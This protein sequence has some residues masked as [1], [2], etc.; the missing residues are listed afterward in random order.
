MH[1]KL[2]NFLVLFSRLQRETNNSPANL[3]WLPT[4]KSD[5][6][7]L[8][9]DLDSCYKEI[10]SFLSTKKTK[11]TIAPNRFSVK[12]DEFVEN[13]AARVSEAAAPEEA[14]RL[15]EFQTLLEEQAIKLGITLEELCAGVS[16]GLEEER[17]TWGSF[18]PLIDDA[19][20]IM[21]DIPGW[22]EHFVI[23]D[24]YMDIFDDKMIGAWNFFKDTIG[25]DY[26]AIYARWR[27]APE[28]FI[29][30]QALNRDITPIVDLY[31]EAVRTYIFGLTVSS[32]A[33]CRAVLEH[34]LKKHYRIKGEDLERIIFLAEKRHNH[35][36]GLNLKAKKNDA[37]AVLHR[38]EE[39]AKN[40]DKAALDFLIALRHVVT[41]IPS[42]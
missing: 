30:L 5:L 22:I 41:H 40:L 33:M 9:Y 38:Y 37:N 21:S 16:E 7:S 13:W 1:T 35:L 20:A 4:E 26:S 19:A 23:N 17:T 27:N 32:V 15:I 36:K 8:C 39:R 25:I 42:P 34:V 10:L 18:D 2:Q 14:R 31:N 6:T 3:T 11:D 12:W 28:L 24:D 29:P